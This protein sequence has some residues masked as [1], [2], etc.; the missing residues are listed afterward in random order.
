MSKEEWS[1]QILDISSIQIG[2]VIDGMAL[3]C[4]QHKISIP[5]LED[6]AETTVKAI[7]KKGF[8][9]IRVAPKNSNFILRPF[10]LE[11]LKAKKS[12]YWVYGADLLYKRHS[13]LYSKDGLFAT[14]ADKDSIYANFQKSINWF[15][16][17]I[18]ARPQYVDYFIKVI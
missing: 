1:R 17:Y 16:K 12:V 6:I 9:V 4:F 10:R 11:H 14:D 15:D 18:D 3:D 2:E 5:S 7:R 8:N 13:T